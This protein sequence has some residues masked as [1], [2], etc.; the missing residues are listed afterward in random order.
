MLDA[1]LKDFRDNGVEFIAVEEALADPGSNPTMSLARNGL[2][3]LESGPF[4][5]RPGGEMILSSRCRGDQDRA[6]RRRGRDVSTLQRSQP[7]G[8]SFRGHG[9]AWSRWSRQSH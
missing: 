2:R 7:A 4:H 8:S 5:A 3:V 6:A 9:G 1:V